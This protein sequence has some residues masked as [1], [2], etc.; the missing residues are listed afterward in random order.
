MWEKSFIV[1]IIV[2]ALGVFFAL[3][4][5]KEIRKSFVEYSEELRNAKFTLGLLSFVEGCGLSTTAVVLYII[6][7]VKG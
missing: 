7:L 4:G 2:F 1:L 6:E 3:L 5:V